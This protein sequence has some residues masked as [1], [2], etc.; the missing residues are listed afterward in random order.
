[1]GQV[2]SLFFFL[3]FTQFYS[4]ISMKGVINLKEVLIKYLD[5]VD[6]NSFV[7]CFLAFVVGATV[8]TVISSFFDFL[9]TIIRIMGA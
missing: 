6:D 7:C 3:L 5:K 8:S 9:C 4:I 2:F 1:M